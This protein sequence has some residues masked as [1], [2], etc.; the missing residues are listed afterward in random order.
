MNLDRLLRLEDTTRG[1]FRW[2]ET[3]G[4]KQVLRTR[5]LNKTDRHALIRKDFEVQSAIEVE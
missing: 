1:V 4:L 5:S 2:S 3:A